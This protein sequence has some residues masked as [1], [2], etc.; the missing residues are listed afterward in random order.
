MKCL[1]VLYCPD[2]TV[3]AMKKPS[4]W[5]LCGPGFASGIPNQI[6]AQHGFHW[7]TFDLVHPLGPHTMPWIGIVPICISAHWISDRHSLGA[8]WLICCVSQSNKIALR[9]QNFRRLLSRPFY[10][11]AWRINGRKKCD[12]NGH[13]SHCMT[14]TQLTMSP[15]SPGYLPMSS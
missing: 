1:T 15:L 8:S 14:S 2:L 3:E 11:L 9:I 6:E 7:L 5:E 10:A 13:A 4:L 12:D